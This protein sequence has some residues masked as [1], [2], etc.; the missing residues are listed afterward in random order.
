MK[1]TT[2]RPAHRAPA[3]AA[4]SAAAALSVA[5][6]G[7]AAPGTA[8]PP[9]VAATASATPTPGTA[10][11][12][13]ASGEPSPAPASAAVKTY[14]FP[15]G[16]LSFQYPADWKVELFPAAQTPSDSHTATVI[17]ASGTQQATVYAG[18]IADVVS[19]P[20]SRT[21][22]ESEPVPGLAQQTAPAAH[23]SFYVDRAGDITTYRL[24]LTAGAPTAG[25]DSRI[26]GIIR[27][28]E[29]VLV[30]DVTFIENPF[31]SDDAAKSWLASAE[32]KSLK[33]LMLSL[34][35]R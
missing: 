3:I 28:G 30:A 10:S 25:D 5:G 22:F 20:V 33:A 35:Y 15:D 23:S 8:S 9:A 18:K 24:H 19:F 32:G 1:G 26:D 4:L 34:S 16:R 11:P 17:D 13:P 12:P 6:C 2:M 7:T 21:V 31:A 29:R 14:T 27:T